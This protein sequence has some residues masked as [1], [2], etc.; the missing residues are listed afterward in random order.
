MTVLTKEKAGKTKIFRLKQVVALGHTVNGVKEHHIVKTTDE[1]IGHIELV[2]QR[3]HV[4]FVLF[5]RDV[6]DKCLHR[7]NV[8][9]LSGDEA[10]IHIP[11]A[12][13]VICLIK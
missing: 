5:Q 9:E 12:Q 11:H 4:V 8:D 6:I 1:F 2:K 13:K 3:D 7:H 10:F